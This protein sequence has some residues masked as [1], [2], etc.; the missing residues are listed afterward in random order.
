VDRPLT[1]RRRILALDIDG[2][3]LRTDKRLSAR[4]LSA[5]RAARDTGVHLV[6]VTGR[7]YPAARHVA[8]ELGAGIPL[9]LHHGALVV[10]PPE[11]ALAAPRVLRCTPL[12]REATLT[13]IRAGRA[14]GADPVV[15]CGF[16]AEG[17]LVVA[18]LDSNNAMLVGYV[19]RGGRDRVDVSDLERDLP[20]D[21]VQVMY[22]GELPAM[23][24]LYPRLV[25]ALG[26]AAR[27]ERTLYPAHGM[28]FLDVLH[29]EVGKATAVAFLQELWSVAVSDTIAIGDNW[30]DRDMLLAAGRG[31]VMGNAE[32]A[33]HEMG[34]E[35]L[36]TNDED[37]VAV[38]IERYVLGQ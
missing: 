31:L 17:R 11:Q 19:D 21:A 32:K 12:S 3:L 6:L 13:A 14:C 22:A 4:T 15:H 36:P 5:V 33:L 25:D 29:P 28:G 10:E 16:Q 24:E 30:N 38:A 18:G 7:R 26:A 35:V 37:G 8:E 23:L 9:V 1:D 2:T 34:L 27:V 20:H